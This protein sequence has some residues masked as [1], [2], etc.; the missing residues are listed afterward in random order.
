MV[1][2]LAVSVPLIAIHR[3]PLTAEY[4]IL[5]GLVL[6]TAAGRHPAA[7]W[8]WTAWLAAIVALDDLRGLQ[9]VIGTPHAADVVAFESR[10]FGGSPV[11]R[12]Q[13]AWGQS[14]LQPWDVVLSIVY[15]AHSPAPLICGAGLWRLRRRF[16]RPFVLTQIGNAVAGLV[17]YLAFPE[18]PPWRAAQLGVLPPVRRIASE[19]VAH[20]G[21]L[22]GVYGGADPLP[23][24]AMPSLHVAYPVIVAWWTVRAFGWRAAWIVLYPLCICVA[25]V[26]LGEHYVVDVLA[27]L[28][29]AVAGIAAVELWTRRAATPPR[30]WG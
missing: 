13:H 8:A 19:V 9:A 7:A 4:C 17:V 15:L 18:A 23:N 1:G 22:S 25:V 11:N 24:A 5:V 30:G 6:W 3:V 21:P 28:V 20:A 10:L 29:L 2:A 26:Y 14:G 27:G 16:F 12:L